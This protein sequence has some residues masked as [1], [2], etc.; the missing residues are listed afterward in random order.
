MKNRSLENLSYDVARTA[1]DP[2]VDGN[3]TSEYFQKRHFD[4]MD[5][6]QSLKQKRQLARHYSPWWSDYGQMMTKKDK[7]DR[8][9]EKVAVDVAWDV[10]EMKV[11]A[12][13]RSDAVDQHRHS[14]VGHVQVAEVAVRQVARPEHVVVLEAEMNEVDRE[15]KPLPDEAQIDWELVYVMADVRLVASHWIKHL[16]QGQKQQINLDCWKDEL[17]AQVDK[18]DEHSMVEPSLTNPFDLQEAEPSGRHSLY[19]MARLAYVGMMDEVL[20]I[21]AIQCHDA[22]HRD[23]DWQSVPIQVI[24]TEPNAEDVGKSLAG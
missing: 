22:A 11:L 19:Q 9:V 23:L 21:N 14:R 5:H 3:Q 4:K 18:V 12:P 16:E 6:L 10:N 8:D 2:F 15:H 17:T 7:A 1:Q 13:N 20:M 24:Q